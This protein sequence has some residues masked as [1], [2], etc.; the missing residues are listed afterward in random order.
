MP[1]FDYGNVN[2]FAAVQ[3]GIDFSQ[4]MIDKQAQRQA[5]NLL[6]QTASPAAKPLFQT[7]Q[8]E[9]GSDVEKHQKQAIAD[10]L[11]FL[12]KAA[13]ALSQIPDDGTQTAR[14]QALTQHILPALQQMGASP[15]DLQQIQGTDLS[16]QA[17]SM[18]QEGAKLQIEKLGNDLVGVNQTT[19]KSKVLYH[20]E[21]TSAEKHAW[22]EV[23]NPDGSTSFIDLNAQPKAAAAPAATPATTP[24]VTQASGQPRGIRDNNPLNL[25]PLAQGQWSGQTGTDG[26]YATFASPEAGMAAAD[27]NLQTYASKYGISTLSGIIN[28][29][30]PPSE[31]NTAAYIQTVAKDLGVDPNAKLDLSNPQVRRAV[32]TSMSKVELGQASPTSQT[33]ASGAPVAATRGIPGSAPGTKGGAKWE[34]LVDPK[35]QTAY[36]YDPVHGTATTLDGKPYT[37][38][39]ASKMNGGG[40]PR[41]ASGLAVQR[42]IQANPSASPDD[43]SQFSAKMKMQANAATAFGTGKQGQT[44]NSLNVAI[45]HLGTMQ[46]AADA[47]RN[48]NIQLFN[49]LGNDFAAATGSEAPTDFDTTKQIVADEVIKS[50]VGTGAAAGDRDK[51]Q[52]LLNRANSPEQLAGAIAQIKKL[53]A[54]QLNGLR[55]QYKNSTGLDDFDSH[56]LPET[57]QELGGLDVGRAS[58]AAPAAK[59]G[60]ARP[61]LSAIFG[62]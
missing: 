13:S 51:A 42:Y 9:T 49:K 32:L 43:I 28:R 21:D 39:G 8:L 20:G 4:G 26:R 40:S 56:L 37:P 7:G 27:R 44:I 3:Q 12:T 59:P 19:G 35:T 23:T 61:P 53:M 29:W 31:N 60:A 34:V 62:R 50:I 38:E 22:H 17:L 16:D 33:P 52:A 57:R 47:L 36:R 1:Q 11:T 15:Q 18:F 41:S 46:K 6:A 54:G 5:G 25:Q 10:H 58:T 2:P 45:D 14:R 55:L 48:G 30:S 24:A